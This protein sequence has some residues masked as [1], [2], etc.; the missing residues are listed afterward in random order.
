M[1]DKHMGTSKHQKADGFA[2]KSD[3]H[4]H[5]LFFRR[6]ME[7]PILHAS[8]WPYP[9]NTVFNAGAALVDGET[10][11][12]V[13]VEDYR[14]ISH[15]TAARSRDG[16]HDWRIDTEPTIMPDPQN[17]PEEIY[18]IE[19]P[20]IVWLEEDMQRWAITY[21]AY[22]HGGPLVS[23]ACTDDFRDFTRYGP[24]MPP[25]DKDAALFPRK[26][27]GRWAM[28]H[29]PSASVFQGRVHMWI[30]FS[31]DL[32]HW[33]DHQI[34]IKSREGGWW[35]AYKIGLSPPPRNKGGL[36]YTLPRG[37]RDPGRPPVPP[38]TCPVGLGGSNE[39]DTP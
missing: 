32:R 36:A 14:G 16:E 33:G 6:S 31:P 18:G 19:D 26:F 38:G 15:L 24:V 39:A 4:A 20:R 12:L 28:I 22:S 8:S 1:S 27:N 10:L 34:V 21:T 25:D 30:S 7:N 13:R 2:R 37:T 29:R 3:L 5:R 35:D 17:H 9:A 11:L 23:L